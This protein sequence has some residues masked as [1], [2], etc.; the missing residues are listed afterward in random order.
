[1]G[2]GDPRQP[3]RAP[4]TRPVKPATAHRGLASGTTPPPP[5]QTAGEEPRAMPEPAPPL[6]RSRT[7]TVDDPLTTML[8]AEVARRAATIELSPEPPEPPG[9]L[10]EAATAE[11][12]DRD[13]DDA[14]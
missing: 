4:G 8:L 2:E 14:R 5:A 3:K 11:P 10:D 9:T 1:M 7:A 13:P 12:V 6:A